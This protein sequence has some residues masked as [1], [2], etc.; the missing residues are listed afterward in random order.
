M[1]ELKLSTAANVGILM[2]D[3]ADHVSGKT[4]LTLTITASKDG[5]AFASISPTVTDLGSGWY[6]VAL[7]S[8]HTDSLGDLLLHASS[9]GADPTDVATRIIAVDKNDAV[10][11]GLSGLANA[12]AGASGG[13][14]TLD[15]S[16]GLNLTKW[17]GGAIPAVNVTGVPKV[18]VVDWLGGTIPAVNVTGIPK[19]DIVDINGVAASTVSGS[20]D[21]N[22][23][24]WRGT[25]VAVPDTAGLPKVT[26]SS[27]TGA[28]QVSLAAGLVTVGTN[29]DKTGYS[30]SQAFPANFST[31]GISAGGKISGVVLIDTLT[32]YTGNTVQTG[33][34][35]A[36]IGAAGAGL[37]ALGDARIAHLDADVS[38]R[39]TFSGGAVASVTGSVASVTGNVGGNVVGSVAS[40]SGNVGGNVVGSVGSV[41]GAVA[42][43]TAPV[44]LSLTQAIPTSNTAQTVGDAL[45]SARAVGFGKWTLVGTALTL[46]AADDTTVVKTF[47]LDSGTVPTTRS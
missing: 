34:N 44:T 8:S 47:T 32:T 19:V 29:S 13:L 6:K 4:G 40:V 10:R 24:D 12:A 7:T 35:F 31:L 16:L 26:I 20:I 5:A 17:L 45:N 11:L 27:G 46:Y 3:S 41:T 36:R 43:V 9:T 37:T 18:D 15:S 30:L 2:I 21:A 39:S 25:A 1:R 42:S 38:S 14:A 33:D 22:V 28:G 23:V